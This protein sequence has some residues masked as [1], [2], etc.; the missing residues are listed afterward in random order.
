MT[1]RIALS[2]PGT[3]MRP[4]KVLADTVHG[5]MGAQIE[6]LLQEINVADVSPGITKWKRL[7]DALA[8]AQNRPQVGNYLIMFTSV[9]LLWCRIARRKLLPRSVDFC[10]ITTVF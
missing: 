7:F 2:T 8:E 10:I 6:R 4:A 1:T 3:S 9:E 5:L